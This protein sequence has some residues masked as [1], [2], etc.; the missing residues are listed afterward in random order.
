MRM[1]NWT[2]HP[3]KRPFRTRLMW[4][5]TAMV[6][7]QVVSG[8]G[9]AAENELA[10]LPAG[11]QPELVFTVL[12]D[13][14]V[15][16]FDKSNSLKLERA[17]RDLN[18]VAP[19][20]AALVV[21][22]DLTER[23]KPE[24]YKAFQSVLEASPH[25]KQVLLTIGNHEYYS[26]WYDASGQWNA[27]TFPNG[28][29]E[30]QSKSRFLEAAG[31][32]RIYEDTQIN[33]YHFILLGSEQ[34]RQ[35]DASIEEDA[36]LSQEQLDFLETQLK[37]ASGSGRPFFVFLHQPLPN[38]I[39]GTSAYPNHRSVVQHEALLRILNKYPQAVFFNGHTH[40]T[41]RLDQAVVTP[42]FTA[43][44]TSS[45]SN[46]LQLDQRAVGTGESEGLVVKVYKDRVWIGA[47]DLMRNEWIWP[48]GL[49][50]G[51]TATAASVQPMLSS[52]G[53]S[54]TGAGQAA[55]PVH[56]LLLWFKS[57][58]GLR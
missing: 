38:T 45:V 56:Q 31:R 57:Q 55:S 13:S 37:A 20:A 58:I 24:D 46:P 8:P 2:R 35:S 5:F 21:N 30:E 52:S 27:S 19:G 51:V 54:L 25:P 28:E 29:S 50:V 44:N 42:S 14:H 9:A 43:V 1:Y 18:A 34:Y 47:R 3:A 17:L 15:S 33:G 36:Y 6:A 22:G 16:S 49:Q 10:A 48:D 40:Y 41:L 12:S 26:S 32:S 11:S 7:A 23:G 39:T 53:S 4:L